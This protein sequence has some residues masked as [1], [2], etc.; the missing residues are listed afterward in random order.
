[1][2]VYAVKQHTQAWQALLD[3]CGM[4]PAVN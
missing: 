4:R 1:R 3:Q 2:Y